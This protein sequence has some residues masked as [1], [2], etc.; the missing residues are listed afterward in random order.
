MRAVAT[1]ADVDAA[2]IHHYFTNKDGLLA[3][4]LVLPI[5]PA[6]VL[7]GLAEDREQAG[8][9]L[10]RR[11]LAIWESTPL[12]RERM[13]AMLRTGLSHE[14]A[15]AM[16][17]DLLGRTVLA[18]IGQVIE[19]DHPQLRAAALGSHLGGLM[20]G[21]YVLQV[22]GLADATPEELVAL[23]GPVW[24]HYLTGSLGDGVSIAPAN[25]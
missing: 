3:A 8:P 6:R 17:R 21:R 4:A 12:V 1:R 22:P 24:Q 18:A 19:A 5:D 9:E 15:A 20:L 25:P 11:V 7:A 13:V 2:L 16:V 10:L 14:H 23:L